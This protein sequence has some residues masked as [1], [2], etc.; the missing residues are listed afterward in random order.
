MKNQAAMPKQSAQS[1]RR[2]T[3]NY[4]GLTVEVITRMP[5]YTSIRHRNREFVVETADLQRSLAVGRA[6]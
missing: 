3:A 2:E 5:N 4:Y 6:A 1:I